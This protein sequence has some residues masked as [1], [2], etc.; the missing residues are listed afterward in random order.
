MLLGRGVGRVL[1]TRKEGREREI[2]K[3]RIVVEE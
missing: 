1:R 2:E 3:G